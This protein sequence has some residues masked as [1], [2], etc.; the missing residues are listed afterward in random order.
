MEPP[1]PPDGAFVPNDS[2]SV[3]LLPSLSVRELSPPAGKLC[4]SRSKA[5]GATATALSE[6]TRLTRA[7]LMHSSYTYSSVLSAMPADEIDWSL[8]SVSSSCCA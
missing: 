3:E 8:P 2:L 6:G 1:S 7:Q 5:S 4:A